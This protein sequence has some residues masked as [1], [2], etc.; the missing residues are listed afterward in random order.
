M[1]IDRHLKITKLLE[2]KSFF[3]FGARG[4]GKSSLIRHQIGDEALIIDLLKTDFLLRLSGR[5][6]DLE[7]LIAQSG[8]LLVVIDEIQKIPLLLN[9]VHRLIEEKGLRFL[10]TGSSARKLKRE[11]AN[12]L[13]GRAWETDLFP[14]SFV[15]IRNFN[16][17]RYLRYGGL[18]TVYLSE[19]PE[20]E[21]DAYVTTYLKEEIQ[22]EGWVRKLPQLNRFLRLAALCNGQILNFQKLGA[23]AQ[24]P[25]STVR[26]YFYLLTDTL[27][28]FMLEPWIGSTKRKAVSTA[29]FYFFDPGVTHMLSGTKAIDRNSDIYGRSFEQW[30][31]MELRAAISYLRI[32]EPLGFWRSLRGDEVDFT[33]GDRLAIEVKS[34][35]NVSER[36]ANGLR[37][38]KEENQFTRYILVSQDRIDQKSGGIEYIY[39]ETFLDLLWHQKLLE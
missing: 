11:N 31:A 12:M 6:G 10:L 4:T 18:P 26:E 27:V 14:L 38:L 3:L 9:E 29:K 24:I 16:L 30:I 39:W 23:D 37:K 17:D 36:D 15:E 35:Q 8:K 5:P 1:Y 32:K 33:V 2:K 19:D 25:P 13:A 22:S 34:S 7:D 20:E 21:L 28:G